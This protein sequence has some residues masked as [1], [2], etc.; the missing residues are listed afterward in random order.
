LDEQP[1]DDAAEHA[2][3]TTS[4]CGWRPRWTPHRRWRCS[5]T[6]IDRA[7]VRL[8]GAGDVHQWWAGS[9][10]G[11]THVWATSTWAVP[12][13][14]VRPLIGAKHVGVV[15][16]EPRPDGD[17]TATFARPSLVRDVDIGDDF[18][19]PYGH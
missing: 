8:V 10:D 15:E 9:L 16:L 17:V 12:P 1:I 2:T 19:S 7:A 4:G 18:A 11:V 3:T 5:S 14:A 13:E 6:G